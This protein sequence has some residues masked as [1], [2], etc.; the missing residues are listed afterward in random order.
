LRRRPHIIAA[1]FALI[2]LGS[3][4]G[5]RAFSAPAQLRAAATSCRSNP[6]LG[7]HDPQRLQILQACTTF[8][9]VVRR[10][11]DIPPDGD[12]T[13]D[14]APD[15]AYASMLNDK[16][17]TKGA[18]H[19]EIIPVDQAGCGSGCTGA[20]VASPRV[21]AHVRLTGAWVFD[22]WVGWNEIHPT[23]KVEILSSGGP[24][25]PPPPPPPSGSHAVHLK[26]WMTGRQLGRH[27]ARGGHG[28]IVLKVDS[29]G[30]CWA[31]SGLAQIG[32]PTRASIRWR[33]RGK[34]GR[35]VLPLGRRFERAGCAVASSA[36]FNAVVEETP[37]Y[38]VLVAT[39]RHRHG[40]IRGQLRRTS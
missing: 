4:G 34:L 22:R 33:E 23:W 28:R 10:A 6:L 1:L 21:G 29:N 8:E 36:F 38:Y 20:K 35:T 13:F 2:A 17:R 37:E 27:G 5:A 11:H 31:F 12:L 3:W 19:M 18:I 39:R 40:A 25:P 15:P 32:T 7:V 30:V 9:G 26:A 24:P 16:N 14:V